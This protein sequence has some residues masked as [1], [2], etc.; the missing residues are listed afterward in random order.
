M[1][2]AKL[3]PEVLTETDY[4][5]WL[6]EV[7]VILSTMNMQ[8]DVWQQNWTYDFRQEYDAGMAPADA[9]DHAHDFWWQHVLDECWT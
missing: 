5:T 4:E 7:R 1:A 8:M 3:H 6:D 9:A 2:T